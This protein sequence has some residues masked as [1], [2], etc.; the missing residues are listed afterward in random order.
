[1][2][3]PATNP[4]PNAAPSRPISRARSRGAATSATDAWA[5]DT[6]APDAPSMIR[7]TKSRASPPATPPAMPVSRLP[8]AV[9]NKEI[10]STGLRPMRSDSRPHNG[11][12]TSC[13]I[14]NEATSTPMV[15]A[16]APNFSAYCG[17]IGSTIPNPIRSMATVVQMVPKPLGRGCRSCDDDRRTSQANVTGPPRSNQRRPI[18]DD[19]V[20]IRRDVERAADHSGRG[21]Q[22]TGPQRRWAAIRYRFGGTPTVQPRTATVHRSTLD[23]RRR[24]RTDSV[25]RGE[26]PIAAE[27]GSGAAAELG[28]GGAVLDD[29]AA[30]LELLAQVVG[31][32]PV[33]VA[34]GGVALGGQGQHVVGDGTQVGAFELEPDGLAD[35][36]HRGGGPAGRLVVVD[37]HG[38]VAGAH[39]REQQVDCAGGVEVVVHEAPELVERLG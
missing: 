18:G 3:G 35:L 19:S 27:P 1:M 39:Q 9:P 20:P 37:G 38:L 30:L 6:L 5:T 15:V 36:G 17:R 7:P 23:R 34:P 31:A 14:E 26:P 32:A 33:A 25:E 11:R 16:E 28:A 22:H 4:T 21:Q 29:V 12:H 2:A 8:T 13:A 24:F 10:S